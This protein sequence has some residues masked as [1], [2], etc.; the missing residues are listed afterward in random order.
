MNDATPGQ[1]KHGQT[2]WRYL[3]PASAR[4][5]SHVRATTRYL[6]DDRPARQHRRFD[7]AAAVTSTAGLGLLTYAV[8]QTDTHSWGSARTVGLLAGAGALLAYFVVR[9]PAA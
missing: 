2:R 4:H 7:A 1:V 6:R 9:W 8:V 5:C 3:R